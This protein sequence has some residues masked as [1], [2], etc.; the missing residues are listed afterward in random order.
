VA[1]LH[2]P[3]FETAY[4]VVVCVALA[5]SGHNF[6][7]ELKRSHPSVWEEL[8]RPTLGTHLTW[9]QDGINLSYLLSRKYAKLGNRRLSHFGDISLISWLLAIGGMIVFGLILGSSGLHGSL[10]I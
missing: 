1:G 5:W 10:S 8:G 4:F 7:G 2:I 3:V 9:K 6:F